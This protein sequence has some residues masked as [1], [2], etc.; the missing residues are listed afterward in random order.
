MTGIN[1]FH[2]YLRILPE[3]FQGVLRMKWFDSFQISLYIQMNFVKFEF[4][5]YHDNLIDD[6]AEMAVHGH[7]ATSLRFLMN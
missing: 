7:R 2:I 6:N 3:E 1:C 5:K 4:E